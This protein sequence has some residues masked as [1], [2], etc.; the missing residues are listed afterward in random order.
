M[1]GKE[2][3]RRKTFSSSRITPA[4]AGK[5]SRSNWVKHDSQDHPRPCGEKITGEGRNMQMQGSPPPMRGKD[6]IY[7]LIVL[8][9]GITPAHAGKRIYGYAALSRDQ[10][11][12]RPCGEKILLFA[13]IVNTKG[14]P[15]PMRGKAYI[16]SHKAIPSRITPAHA[17]KRR[18]RYLA[19]RGVKDHPRPCGEKSH[20]HIRAPNRLGSPPPMRGKA[21]PSMV[22]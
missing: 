6:I 14:S 3:G 13:A 10:D 18:G 21:S 17:G 11:H 1:R 19:G 7:R 12:P 8:N 2:D 22:A 15:P 9:A 16:A 20:R 5:R 4:H